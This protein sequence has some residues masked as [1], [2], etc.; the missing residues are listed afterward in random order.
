MF[1]WLKKI[2]IKSFIADKVET[3]AL[4]VTSSIQIEIGD[5]LYTVGTEEIDGKRV[6]VIAP[7]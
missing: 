7:E 3:K 4:K 5:C 6:L 1:S 2:K